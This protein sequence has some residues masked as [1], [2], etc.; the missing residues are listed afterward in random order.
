MRKIDINECHNI[1]LDIA[2]VFDKICR[3]HEIPYYML[4]G[5]M[6]GAVRHNG[7]IPWDDDMDFGI[8]RE[9]YNKFIELCLNEL[10]FPYTFKYMDNSEY[11]ILGIGKIVDMRTSMKERYSISSNERMGINI[12]VFPLDKTNS[13]TSFFSRNNI[14]R[15]IFKLQKILFI[16]SKDRPFCKRVLANIARIIFPFKKQTLLKYIETK[17]DKHSKD[18]DISMYINISGAWGLKELISIKTFG[19]P[20]LYKFENIELYGVEDYDSY[21]KGLYGNYMK[22]PPESKRHI[23]FDN[24]YIDDEK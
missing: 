1:L 18:N 9:Y 11:C 24:A 8:P 4:G 23:H 19:L 13:D 7:F 15:C 10:K 20:R 3:E 17:F 14:L 12:D 21:L 5:T 22:L 16:N 6:L 2:K